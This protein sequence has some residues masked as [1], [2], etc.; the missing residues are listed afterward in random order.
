MNAQSIAPP[1]F[2][3]TAVRKNGVAELN[4]LYK[5]GKARPVANAP[6]APTMFICPVTVPARSPPTS[7]QNA[8]DGG[9][10]MSA[11]K[12]VMLRKT[13]A[14]ITV[15]ALRHPTSPIAAKAKPT[16]AT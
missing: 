6:N 16:I 10:V 2:S 12:T 1:R 8:Q 7:M 3:A 13:T 14:T 15:S 4:A 5:Y 11:P 9:R